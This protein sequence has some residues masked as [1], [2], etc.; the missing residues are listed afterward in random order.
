M[1]AAPS[2][3]R[4]LSDCTVNWASHSPC[5]STSRLRS[6]LAPRREAE[7][8]RSLGARDANSSRSPGI[9]S[10]SSRARRCAP[11]RPQLAPSGGGHPS[12]RSLPSARPN[13]STE[14][15]YSAPARMLPSLLSAC[16]QRRPRPAEDS[17]RGQME[18]EGGSS[19]LRGKPLVVRCASPRHRVGDGS[20]RRTPRARVVRTA[21]P[22]V[23]EHPREPCP[24]GSAP[25]SRHR[26]SSSG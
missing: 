21:G 8:A 19:K 20:S 23:R 26:T 11:S 6:C 13:I 15:V 5:S 18:K 2:V 1:P 10:T 24:S 22:V 16:R 7:Y 9:G 25:T 17:R 14:L 4:A 3:G 12:A